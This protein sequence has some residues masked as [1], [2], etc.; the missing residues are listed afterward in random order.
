VSPN[1]LVFA[2]RD[3][4]FSKVVHL[5]QKTGIPLKTLENLRYKAVLNP[6]MSTL[7]ALWEEMDG[8]P[9]YDLAMK[10]AD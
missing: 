10:K 7:Q 4:P 9:D 8:N 2:V 6:H 5:H 3:M 1:D